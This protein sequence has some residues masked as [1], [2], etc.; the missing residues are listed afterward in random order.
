MGWRSPGAADG[1]SVGLCVCRQPMARWLLWLSVCL[2]V[3]TVPTV[4]GVGSEVVCKD[5]KCR[6]CQCSR[7]RIFDPCEPPGAEL[8]MPWGSCSP[9]CEE[10]GVAKGMDKKM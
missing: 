8:W 7:T 10:D 3:A 6:L 1:A 4:H 2:T 5:G 9:E